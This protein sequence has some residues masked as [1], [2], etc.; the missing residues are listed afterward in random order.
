MD[1]N[2][3]N[4]VTSNVKSTY[5]KSS[6][7]AKEAYSKAASSPASATGFSDEAA[8]YTPSGKSSGTGVTGLYSNEVDRTA[9]IEKMKADSDAMTSQLRGIVEKM[10]SQQGVQIGTADDI[11]S[12]LAEGNFTVDEAAQAKAKEAISEDGYWGVEQTSSRI[13][14]FAKALSG[15]DTSK[16]EMLLDAFKEGF[17]QATKTWGK[18]L[19]DISNQTYDAVLEKFDAWVNGT[20]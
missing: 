13:V 1:M 18:D 17:A 6:G 19:P 9:L 8:V 15:G 12:F 4:A 11:W 5:T 10:M 16:A 3:T 2:V 7:V 14:D 20:E